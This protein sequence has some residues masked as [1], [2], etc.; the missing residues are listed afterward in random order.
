MAL[1][2]APEPR[3]WGT[4]PQTRPAK[5]LPYIWLVDIYFH[6][7]EISV[8][9]DVKFCKHIL[10][11]QDGLL[12]REVVLPGVI[13]CLYTYVTTA[14]P[15]DILCV[16]FVTGFYQ[17]LVPFSH[18]SVFICFIHHVYRVYMCYILVQ[19]SMSYV[20][21][22]SPIWWCLWP[23]TIVFQSPGRSLQ[24]SQSSLA[25]PPTQNHLCHTAWTE[26]LRFVMLSLIMLS[27]SALIERFYSSSA[28]WL[29]QE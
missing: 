27:L 22:L 24:G 16:F 8:T 28:H 20:S 21:L 3:L 9:I 1:I 25:V 29:D 13:N 26:M 7:S 17:G 14:N 4:L 5:S 10:S 12:S 6:L 2:C 23:T 11:P 19:N 18:L 15:S